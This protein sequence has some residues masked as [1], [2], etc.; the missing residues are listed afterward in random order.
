[1][2]VVKAQLIGGGSFQMSHMFDTWAI[3]AHD[4]ASTNMQGR[5]V[6]LTTLNSEQ[7]KSRIYETRF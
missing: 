4:I 6:V 7:S 5:A 2:V 3:V 1:M